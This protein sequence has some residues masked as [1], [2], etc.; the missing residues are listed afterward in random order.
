MQVGYAID[1]HLK[2]GKHSHKLHVDAFNAVRDL[3]SP[4]RHFQLFLY[5]RHL[6]DRPEEGC[7]LL[8]QFNRQFAAVTMNVAEEFDRYKGLEWWIF[9]LLV[10]VLGLCRKKLLESDCG[11]G[12]GQRA[13]HGFEEK[14]RNG[15]FNLRKRARFS[16]GRLISNP[17]KNHIA[18]TKNQG[19]V[20]GYAHNPL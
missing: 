9:R 11:K 4:L 14:L 15:N 1:A 8:R 16:K 3:M 10:G 5:P 6:I 13:P 19:S 2:L 7:Q 18:Q 17:A 20:N 12:R